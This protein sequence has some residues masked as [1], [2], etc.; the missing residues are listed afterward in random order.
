LQGIA[1]KEE[2]LVQYRAIL[3]SAKQSSTFSQEAAGREGK[4]RQ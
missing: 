3:L 4:R 1:A 2:N